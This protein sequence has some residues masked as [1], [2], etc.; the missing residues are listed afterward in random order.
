MQTTYS[1][2]T[3]LWQLSALH[4]KVD[5]FVLIKEQL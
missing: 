5:S 2:T 3:M 4:L 1:N